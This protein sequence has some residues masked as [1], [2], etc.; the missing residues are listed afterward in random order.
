MV[1]TGQKDFLNIWLA[2][3]RHSELKEKWGWGG[4]LYTVY[5]MCLFGKVSFP[6]E[7]NL[8]QQ[9]SL[10]LV[11]R[12]SKSVLVLSFVTTQRVCFYTTLF[13]DDILKVN[14]EQ[15]NRALI[16][17]AELVKKNRPL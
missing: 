7:V 8:F 15:R 6:T 12:F 16:E 3:L 13:W 1:L 4:S 2:V 14:I 9:F 10:E 5:V 11:D 17:S